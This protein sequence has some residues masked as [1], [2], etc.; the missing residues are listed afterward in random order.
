M[1][2]IASPVT[3]LME[4]SATYESASYQ[5]ALCIG[6]KKKLIGIVLG[7]LSAGVEID[8]ETYSNP[9]RSRTF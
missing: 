6:D 7:G 5:N 3:R 9:M 8:G 4:Q 2:P 1:K